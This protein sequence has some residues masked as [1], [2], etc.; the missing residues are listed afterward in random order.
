LVG[1]ALTEGSD[2]EPR[3]HIFAGVI[4][5]GGQTG[6]YGEAL[7]AK[8]TGNSFGIGVSGVGYYGVSAESMHPDGA[9]TNSHGRLYGVYASGEIALSGISA[10]GLH[11]ISYGVYGSARALEGNPN[12][13]SGGYFISD[14]G[15]GITAIA[16]ADYAGYFEGNVYT[17]GLYET[18]DEKLKENV[19]DFGEATSLLSTLHP[20]QYQFSTDDRFKG[21][22]LP[23]GKHYGLIAQ[24]VEKVMPELVKESKQMLHPLT[25]DSSNRHNP[26]ASKEFI[27]IKAVNYTG[28]IPVMI[29]SMQEMDSTLR[30]KDKQILE[31]KK[32]IDE[33]KEIVSRLDRSYNPTTS[34]WMT[35]NTPNPVI[36]GT[37]IKYFIPQDIRAARILI[38]NAKGQQIQ[39]YNV[40]GT[41]TVNFSAA[42]LPSG[43]YTYT[44]VGDGET[45]STKKLIIAR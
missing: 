10:A 14:N 31:L 33:I 26:K 25:L 38:S 11:E 16:S 3:E 30:E 44:L 2:F 41:G 22:H 7:A 4:G 19:S 28:L 40:S 24:E 20:K 37:T 39:V 36:A 34:A 9:G 8:S 35:Q 13:A 23:K 21:L 12:P 18:S 42:T 45:L 29:R 6:V 32:E 17:T 15:R 1:Q 27:K 5:F 43:T